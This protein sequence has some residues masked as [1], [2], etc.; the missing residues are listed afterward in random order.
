MKSMLPL[1]GED[2]GKARG[3]GERIGREVVASIKGKEHLSA[4]YGIIRN[5]PDLCHWRSM[6]AG[7]F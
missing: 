1:G 7:I 2:D 3:R 4:V 5:F 6:D